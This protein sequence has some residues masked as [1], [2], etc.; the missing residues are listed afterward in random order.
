MMQDRSYLFDRGVGQTAAAQA[1]DNEEADGAQAK[2]D[3]AVPANPAE[4]WIGLVPT[5]YCRLDLFDRIRI[6]RQRRI[7]SKR[8]EEL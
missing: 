5:A 7:R 2:L 6:S 3:A 4:G 1:R 8:L